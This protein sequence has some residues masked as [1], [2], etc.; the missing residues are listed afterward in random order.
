MQSYFDENYLNQVF[1]HPYSPEE[2]GHV[3][4][5]H[6]TL[7]QSLK[8][9]YFSNL[10]DLLKRLDHF[11]ITYNNKRSH[12]SVAGLCS[13]HFW[14]LW[15]NGQIKMKT[16]EKKKATFRLLIPY[17]DILDEEYIADYNYRVMRT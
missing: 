8:H 2:N 14:S 10:L 6:K 1:T 11:Y 17:Q 12:G 16:Y 13:S 3:E 7:E 5:F 9:N 15:E 4:S